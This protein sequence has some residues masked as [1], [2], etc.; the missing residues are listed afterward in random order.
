MY[1][2][3]SV[4]SHMY[5]LINYNLFMFLF[6]QCYGHPRDLHSFPT[7][8]LPILNPPAVPTPGMAGGAK[9][10]T[11]ACGTDRKSTRLNSSHQIISYAVFCLK[12]KKKKRNNEANTKRSSNTLDETQD[13][14]TT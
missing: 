4:Y 5:P 11:T 10:N 8:A 12:K 1:A 2:Q 13:L 9:L 6:F 3:I 14:K 7:R